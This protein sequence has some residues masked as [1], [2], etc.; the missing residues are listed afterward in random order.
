MRK[1]IFILVILIAGS[2]HGQNKNSKETAMK[3]SAKEIHHTEEE[4]KQILSPEQYHI[5]REKGTDRPF[6]GKY[7]LTR[8]KGIY[9]CAACGN[10]LFTS[11]MKFDS[12]CGWPSFDKEIAGGK[13][14]KKTDYSF[15]MVRTEILCAQCGS[16]LG[17]LF[18]DGPTATK[19]RYC[20]NSTSIDFT[21]K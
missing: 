3:N 13:I 11:D 18:D 7:Y 9:Q 17:H 14:I 12:E 2:C 1:L 6:T 21:K 16:H 4:W 15:G 20:V 10:E 5:L 19:L 8:D